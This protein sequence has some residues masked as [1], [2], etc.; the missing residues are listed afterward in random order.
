MRLKGKLI[1]WHAD[2]AFGFIAPTGGGSEVFIHKS[3]FTNK[4]RMPKTSD[5]IT[6]SITKDNNG[7]YCACDAIFPGEKL[8]K[9]PPKK[10]NFFSIYLALI[11]LVAIIITFTLGH[12]PQKL[13]SVYLGL[14]VLTFLAYAI[15]KSKAQR[16]TWRT[17]E[18]T[19]HILALAGGWP[20]AAL[21][22]Q[23]LRHK[24]AKQ[25]F[26]NVFW[27]TVMINLAVLMWLYTSSGT[28]YLP[29]LA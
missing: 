10:F 13:M 27:L 24:S 3:A 25:T 12:L 16:G 21:A 22:Q 4:N 14:S 20:G 11:F 7:R 5:I 2:K 26:R 9:K 15:D 28:K 19:L 8:K 17:P 29:L 6:F 23:Y 1:K 18:S